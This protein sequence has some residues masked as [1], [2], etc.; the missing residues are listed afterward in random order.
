MLNAEKIRLMTDLAVYERKNKKTVFQINN[1]YRQDYLA[2]QLLSAFVRFTFSYGVLACV[3]ALFHIDTLFYNINLKGATAML[4]RFGFLY[5]AG[6]LLYLFVT[7]SVAAGRYK[8]A[9]RGMLLYAT[10]LK[11]LGR[12][13]NQMKK[14]EVR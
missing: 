2:G 11:R 1:Y 14:E 5:L 6:L 9:K 3:Y 13:Y 10:K 4:N 8:R 12:K 7:Y